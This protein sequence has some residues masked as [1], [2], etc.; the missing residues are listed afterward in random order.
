MEGF[1]ADPFHYKQFF[2]LNQ[3]MKSSEINKKIIIDNITDRY[4]TL[5]KINNYISP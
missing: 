2:I 5:I 1:L 4:K 3:I